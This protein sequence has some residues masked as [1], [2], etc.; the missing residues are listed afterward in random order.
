MSK[1]TITILSEN[2][3]NSATGEVTEGIVVMIDGVLKDLIDKVKKDLS[4]ED[5][6]NS[7]FIGDV[8]VEG[9][10]VFI[11]KAKQKTYNLFK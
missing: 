1:N 4:I 3:E 8:I 7:D 2:Y 10:N 6:S 5:I 11:D 9:I